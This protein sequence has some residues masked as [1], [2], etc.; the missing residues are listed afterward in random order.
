MPIQYRGG[1]LGEELLEVDQEGRGGS[2]PR[3]PLDAPLR[4]PESHKLDGI[5][6]IAVK[7]KGEE[8]DP[9]FALFCLS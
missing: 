6:G 9:V 1:R 3:T 5:Y 4:R 8:W 2:T 7:K